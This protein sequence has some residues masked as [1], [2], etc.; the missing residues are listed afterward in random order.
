MFVVRVEL[1]PSAIHGLG[2]FTIEPIKKDQLVWQFDP[3]VDIVLP[4]SE[5]NGCHPVVKEML[6]K[7]TYVE[8][9]QGR[10]VMI[11]CGDLAKFMNHSDQPNLY[12]SRDLTLNFALRDI[13]AGEELTCNYYEFDIKAGDKLGR[14]PS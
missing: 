4:A 7:W 3:R 13:D 11:L 1:K 6:E 12:D 2:C 14:W 9:R 5:H 10:E 8:V